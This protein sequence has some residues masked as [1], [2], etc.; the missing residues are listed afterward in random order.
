[1]SSERPVLDQTLPNGLRLLLREDH[2]APIASF[3]TWY[4]VGSW[5]ESPGLT[6]ISHWVE[7]MQFK[8]TPSLAKGQVFRDVS[9][10][11]GTLNALTSNDWTA[12]Y[13]TLPVERLDL[14]LAIESDRMVNSLFDS[15]ETESERT[16]ILSER[17]GA[18][19]NPSYLLYE[20][21]V[22][23]AF[24]AHPY[25]H[26]VIGHAA[27]LRAIR[28]DDLYTHYR[29][30]YHPANAFIA[31]TGDF[32]AANLAERIERAFGG[33][34]AGSAPAARRVEEPPQLGERRVTLRRPAPTAY[35][36]MA[37]HAPAAK[38][39]DTPA[40]LLADA[41][42][43]GGKGMGFGGGGAMGR[44]SRLYRAL[45][46]TG[47]ARSAGS[48]FGLYA[49]PYLFG[50]GVTALPGTEPARIEAVVDAELGRLRDE[51]VS[52]E[53]LT[54]ALKQVAAQYVYSL[55]GVTNQAFWLGQME[56]VDSYRRVDTFLAA[57]EAVTPDE[58]RRV[59]RTYLVDRSRT[60]G[61]LLPEAA[62]GGEAMGDAASPQPAALS[63]RWF[64]RST[65]TAAP[66]NPTAAFERAE[67]PNGMVVLTQARPA[68][69][70]VV[71]RFRVQA[72][73]VRDP[74]GR[75]G[76]ANFTARMLPRGGE[77]RSF[78]ELNEATDA[79]GA[80]LSSDAGRHFAEVGVRC[81]R[82]DLPVLLDLAADVLR[83]P[84][85]PEEEVEKVRNELLT[86]IREA[87][88]DTRATADRL[89]RRL[90]FPSP[91]PYGR[92]VGG[93]PETIPTLIRDDLVAFHRTA[94]GP[95][96]TT[97]AIV[98]GIGGLDEATNLL[99]ERF[100]DWSERVS[101]PPAIPP[102]PAPSPGQ[103]MEVGIPGKSQANLA[104][105]FP[106]P[107][108]S[109]PAY[110]ALDTANLI[111]G[112]LGLMGR[113]GTRVRDE[114]GLA[115]SV[116]SQLEPGREVGLWGAR[117]GVD[118]ANL[119]RARS[120]IVAEVRL[121]AER[122]AT[123]EE[124]DDAKSFL[125]GVLPLALESNDGVAATLLN[126]EYHGLGLDYLERYP[127]IIGALTRDELVAAWSTI[128]P[129]RLALA[130]AGPTTNEV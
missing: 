27:D 100:G 12:Y 127:S 75:D 33:I 121:L 56:I 112:R 31:A 15:E 96:V 120:G 46:A 51:L 28:R 110:Y 45:V 38:H 61:W 55:E 24:R 43:S 99:G 89:L 86:G 106:T 48:G 92:R 25:R 84:L 9:R 29:R 65:T 123:R 113:L 52:E 1:M 73:A 40:L 18:E 119:E 80:S 59:A 66:R 95:N 44:S 82:D 76:L 17:Q 64:Y 20:E 83:R 36:R 71:V 5:D 2:S 67:L 6:G 34:E 104:L 90:L 62:G 125:T 111:L 117:A 58:L 4:R 85:F 47:L 10:N 129:E 54:R 49:D 57:V 8:G 94:F 88:N 11:G 14:A 93:D 60:V 42:L 116:G 19:N 118:P 7:H 70:S 41:V 37:Y 105:G 39:P 23:A 74:D 69:Q 68:E 81:L 30:Y 107:P 115:Y 103:R 35:L 50:V 128:D 98:G 130:V 114:Q 78:A 124:I 16:V 97:V 77:R 72:G 108:R 3:W 63:N 109:D 26:M 21:V 102:P 91:H 22:G 32:N 79:L 122:G 101:L 87:D 13:E 126:I 53:E